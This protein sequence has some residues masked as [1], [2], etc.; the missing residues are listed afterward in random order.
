MP[1]PLDIT[2]KDMDPSPAVEARVRE[3]VDR[4]ER[5]HPRIN[6]CYA[7]IES[8]HRHQH[9]GKI[10]SVR[11]DVRVPGGAVVVNRDPGMDHAHEDIMVAV[12]DA[13]DAMERRLEDHTRRQ[14]GSVKTHEEP[15]AGR[16][17]RLFPADGYGFV[18]TPDGQ[19]IYFHENSVVGARF[20]DLAVGD[21]VRLVVAEDESAD[22]PQATTVHPISALKTHG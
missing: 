16:I 9:K 15:L 22:G 12:R 1:I 19:E 11:V 2:F 7:V 8:P 10:Y 21:T 3:R 18:A 20:A 13:F 17:I 4:L 5:F 6:Y 14:R